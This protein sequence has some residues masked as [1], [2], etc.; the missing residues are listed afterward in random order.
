MNTK[1]LPQDYLKLHFIV[2]ILSFTAIL[3]RL[4]E[5][6]TL[7][8]VFY[9]TL[10]ATLGM[11]VLATFQKKNLKISFKHSLPLLG[12]GAIISLHWICFFGS[13]RA[14]TVAVSLVTFSTTSFFTSILEP[15]IRKTK[16]SWVEVFL[17]ILVVGGM[18]FVFAFESKYLTGILVGIVGAILAAVFSIINAQFAQKYD[19]QIVTFYEMLGAF[20]SSWIYIPIIIYFSKGI[21]YQLIPTHYDWLWLA[22]LGLVCTVYPYNEM[23]KLLKKISAFTLNL[24]INMEPIYG[25]M[26]AY[27]IFGEKEKM[28]SGF[29]IGGALILLSVVLYPFLKKYNA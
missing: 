22:I 11:L 8:V 20:L 28:T 25:I 24:S 1:P 3:G 9:R 26:M 29:Y 16:V 10:L 12:V 19:A 7:G 2:A 18:Y 4:T 6:S 15:Y 17:G 27:F 13:A 5:V 21:T 23:M 14:S